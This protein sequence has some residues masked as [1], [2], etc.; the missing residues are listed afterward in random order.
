M[1]TVTLLIA[2]DLLH[3]IDTAQ[4]LALL[5]AREISRAPDVRA[6]YTVLTLD[7]PDAPTGTTSIEPIFQRAADG[8]VTVMS[9]GWH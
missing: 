4:M 9:M 1:T 2:D 7:V 3:E 5:S 8:T 6:G